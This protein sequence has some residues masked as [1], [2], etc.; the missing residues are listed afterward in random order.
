VHAQLELL[1]RRWQRDSDDAA[2]DELASHFLPLAQTLADRYAH[3]SAPLADLVQVAGVGLTKA[4]NR[5]DPDGGVPFQAFAIPTILGE[6]QRYSRDGSLPHHLAHAA[7]ECAVEVATVADRLTDL[8][9]RAP[10]IRQLAQHVELSLEQVLHGLLATMGHEA[11][12]LDGLASSAD[13]DVSAVEDTLG[14]DRIARAHGLAALSAREREILHMRFSE[15]MTQ[16]EI[17]AR[18]GISPMQIARV[19][20]GSLERL[21]EPLDEA[22]RRGHRK[23]A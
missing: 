3:T 21:R 9:G 6:L 20:R 15:G 17:A 13:G 4:I 22:S 12:S 8:Y 10:T 16:S 2:R 19:L 1:F 5:F 7:R 23:A 18:V 11:A 14:A